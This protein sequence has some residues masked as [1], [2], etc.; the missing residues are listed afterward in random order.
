MTVKPPPLNPKAVIPNWTTLCNGGYFFNPRTN[1]HSA[2]IISENGS[3][4]EIMAEALEVIFSI[5]GLSS[6]L[7]PTNIE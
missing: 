2:V 3:P 5:P 4:Q 7:E 1:Q 6:Q